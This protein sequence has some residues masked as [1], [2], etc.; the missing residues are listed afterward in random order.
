MNQTAVNKAKETFNELFGTEGSLFFCPGRINLIGDHIDYNGGWVL[1]AAISMGTYA[2]AQFNGTNT[3]RVFSCNFEQALISIDLSKPDLKQFLSGH[4]ASYVAGSL[5]EVEK[6]NGIKLKGLDLVFNGDIPRGS[7]LSSS[8]SLEV[9]VCY[10]VCYL[11]QLPIHR[12]QLSIWGQAAENEFVGMNCGIMDQFAV[13]NGKR[14]QALLLDC[15]TLHFELVPVELE[16]YSLVVMN[17][18][19]PRKLV[20]SKYNERRQESELALEQIRRNKALENLAQA[21][22]EDIEHLPDEKIRRRAKHVISENRRVLESVNALR[23]NDL[24]RFGQL[25]TESHES[26]KTDYETSGVEMDQ[27]VAAALQNK[28]CLGARMMGGGFGGCALAVVKT[29]GLEQFIQ[30]VGKN[31]RDT[32]GYQAEFYIPELADGVKFIE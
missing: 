6:A 16:N 18:C 22:L 14:N 11:H 1:P 31:Y 17:S 4:W 5:L 20:E 12:T 15:Q 23:T 19:K 28:D 29:L 7:G 13:A 30:E 21:G 3:F 32:V 26:L 27:L 2:V 8:A 25:L 24:K 10:L 9:L